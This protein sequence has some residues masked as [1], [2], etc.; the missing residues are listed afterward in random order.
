MK[1]FVTGGT[2]FVGAP[3]VKEAI[4]NGHQILGLARSDESAAAL[5]AVGAEIIRGDLEDLDV[6]RKG[7]KESEGVVHIGFVQD[8]ENF[9]N[10]L[11]ID[12]RAVKAMLESLEGTNKFF[13]YTNG[14]LVLPTKKGETADESTPI[15]YE[16]SMVLLRKYTEKLALSYASKGVRV[17]SVRLA[18]SVHDKGDRAFIGLLMENAKKNHVSYYVEDGENVWSAVHRDN[19]AVLYRLAV[20]KAPAGS[21]LHA[22]AELVPAK[23]IAMAIAEATNIPVDSIS[24][25]QAVEKLGF[26]GTIIQINSDISSEKTRSLLGW[27]PTK[28]DLLSDIKENY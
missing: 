12:Q 1:L 17:V 9:Q 8:F 19:A 3:F 14:L 4:S 10:S 22:V 11:E 25:A 15:T 26:I 13:A 18:L 6:L 28:L 7:S 21:I 5:K 23:K 27:V 2:G 20:E 16:D 24:S